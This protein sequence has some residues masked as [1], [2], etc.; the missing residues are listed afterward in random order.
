VLPTKLLA[1]RRP[2][3]IICALLLLGAAGDLMYVYCTRHTSVVSPVLA[4]LLLGLAFGVFKDRPLA[5]RTLA[6]LCVLTALILPFGVINPLAVGDY[7]AQGRQPPT[8]EATLLWA[9]PVDLLLLFVAFLID[10][11]TLRRNSNI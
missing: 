2:A 10:P 5:L 3:A 9:V 11:R 6:F 8:V 4:V 1:L 7:L